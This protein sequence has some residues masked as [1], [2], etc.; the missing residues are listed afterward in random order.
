MRFSGMRLFAWTLLAAAVLGNGQAG[1][2]DDGAYFNDQEAASIADASTVSLLKSVTVVGKGS[3][4]GV[5]NLDEVQAFAVRE[6]REFLPN[7]RFLDCGTPAAKQDPAGN[8]A[9]IDCSTRVEDELAIAFRVWTVGTKKYP[10][11]FHL[12]VDV[13]KTPVGPGSAPQLV[14]GAEKLG[15]TKPNRVQGIVEDYIQD[16]LNHFALQRTLAKRG[17]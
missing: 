8:R 2:A 17:Q 14:V 7:M 6:A 3:V 16:F 5:I 15:F 13:T 9:P 10:V 1:A 11:A 12:K 4:N